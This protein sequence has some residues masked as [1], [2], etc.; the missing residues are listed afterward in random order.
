MQAF[1]QDYYKILPNLTLNFG[2]RYMRQ[3]GWTETY[4]RLS[5]FL[6]N[7]TNPVTGTSGAIGFAGVNAP[8]AAENDINFFL[9]PRAGLS[10]SPVQNWVVR[11]GYGIFNLPWSATSYVGGM[12]VGWNVQGQ[13]QVT[14]NITPIFQYLRWRKG[15]PPRCRRKTNHEPA[16]C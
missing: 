7:A 13:E 14:D 11:A 2:V 15:R 9:Q 16:R 12:G 4:N 10:W 8:T 5:T 3:T 1:V 6:P